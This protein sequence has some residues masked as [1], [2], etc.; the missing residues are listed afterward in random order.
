MLPKNLNEHLKSAKKRC[1]QKTIGNT[2]PQFTITNAQKKTVYYTSELQFVV[3]M[4]N[5]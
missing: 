1:W 2:L 4:K 3:M 5:K